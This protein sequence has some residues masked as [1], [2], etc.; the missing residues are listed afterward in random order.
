MQRF[1]IPALSSSGQLLVRPLRID[2]SGTTSDLRSSDR[3]TKD[4]PHLVGPVKEGNKAHASTKCP[5]RSTQFAQPATCRPAGTT[6]LGWPN[7]ED[8][9]CHLQHKSDKIMNSWHTNKKPIFGQVDLKTYPPP[10]IN[11]EPTGPSKGEVRRFHAS[12]RVAQSLP[13]S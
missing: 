8:Q 4:Q 10:P 1:P 2:A 11:M 6:H 12:G 7:I 13:I 3:N 5:N 9:R